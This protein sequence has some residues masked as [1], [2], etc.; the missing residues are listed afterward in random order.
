MLSVVFASLIASS[1]IH[2]E[3]QE[4]H[5]P[6]HVTL[7]V[8]PDQPA[9]SKSYYR[10]LAYITSILGS[11]SLGANLAVSSENTDQ[12]V[13]YSGFTVTGLGLHF[14]SQYFYRKSKNSS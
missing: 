8:T 5:E 9:I 11:I 10:K 13:L 7:N 3:P 4:P 6:M 14:L 12:S 2:R 1:G